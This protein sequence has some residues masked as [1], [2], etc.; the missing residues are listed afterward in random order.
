MKN[1]WKNFTYSVNSPDGKAII[2]IS[3]DDNLDIQNII[4][5]IGKSGSSVAAWCN[6][7]GRMAFYAIRNTS[8]DE[9]A[10]ELA[11]IS[12]DRVS[13]T[14]GMLCRSGPEALAI[15]LKKYK[16]D[17]LNVKARKAS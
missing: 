15:A 4:M 14:Y 16:S 6:A 9:V 11:D 7:L 2:S 3:Y 13:Y 5:T 10:E 1:S 12:T 8:L 17:I